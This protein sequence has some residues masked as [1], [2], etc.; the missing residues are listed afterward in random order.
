MALDIHLKIAGIEGESIN[1]YHP[2]EIDVL[3]WSWGLTQ[4]G[5]TH[6]GPGA[7]SGKVNVNDMHF[8]KYVDKSTPALIKASCAGTH[9]DTC[10]LV[11]SKAGGDAPVEYFKIDMTEVLI[12][13]YNTGGSADGLDR[14]VEQISFNFRKF[15]ITYTP[16]D[17]KGMGGGAI[18]A[19]WDVASGK[20]AS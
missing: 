16:Q 4:S 13:S 14:V 7:G 11:V 19:G 6:L 20:A 9:I 10:T 3:N 17:A 12:S 18:P 2:N 15:V 5:T 8:S 1:E